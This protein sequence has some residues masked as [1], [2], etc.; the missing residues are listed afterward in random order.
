MKGLIMNVASK[1]SC[2]SCGKSYAW[3]PEI[4][5]KRVK[6]KCGQPLLIPK[7]DP[8]GGA[9]PG[10]L[11]DFAALA[12][13]AGAAVAAPAARGGPTCPGCG[14]GVEPS[15]VICVNCGQNLK[16]G[17]KLKTAKVGAGGA[18]AVPEYRSFGIKGGEEPM[19]AKK[20]K[21]IAFSCVGG[22]VVI[23]AVVLAVVI[24]AR[25]KERERLARLN[26]RPA[27]LEKFLDNIEKA[28]GLNEAMHQGTLYDG[29]KD[30][31]N[32]VK[33]MEDA[34]AAKDRHRLN[35]RGKWMYA[36][37]GPE[38][39]SFLAGDPKNFIQGHDHDASVKLVDD[40]YAMG[41]TKIQAVEKARDLNGGGQFVIGLVA[42]LPKDAAARKKIFAWYEGL[43]KA[44]SAPDYPFQSEHQQD[45]LTA[46]FSE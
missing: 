10:G 12:A 28:G 33:A 32:T 46:E 3:K 29:I 20:K 6:C 18:A 2:G 19:S 16:T 9:A 27:K 34:A 43:E 22:Q 38:M 37:E 14:A 40:L 44:L 25:E 45:V 31:P 7:T 11:D 30:D 21:I 26:A 13:D 41:A 35:E 5:G 4:A 8:A 24:P 36:A 23:I 1:F 39:K 42:T 15:A 17:Q